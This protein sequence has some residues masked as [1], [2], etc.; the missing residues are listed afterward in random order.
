[1]IDEYSAG[2]WY[3]AGNVPMLCAALDMFAMNPAKRLQCR[4]N[5]L[6]LARQKFLA[7]AIYPNMA[8][9]LQP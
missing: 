3:R 5:A 4:E 1:L 9:F 2:A 8:R 7:S 6:R